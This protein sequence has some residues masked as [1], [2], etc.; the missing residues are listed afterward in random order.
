MSLNLASSPN[1]NSRFRR[2]ELNDGVVFR[3]QLTIPNA[4]LNTTV[5][6]VQIRGSLVYDVPTNCV[7]Y[8]NGQQ[9]FPL[10]TS[11]LV[12]CCCTCTTQMLNVMTQIVNNALTFP[13]PVTITLEEGVVL[14]GHLI[15][16]F[17]NG[18]FILDTLAFGNV[19]KVKSL[20]LSQGDSFTNGSGDLL[21]TLLPAPQSAPVTCSENCEFAMR[22]TALDLI[23]IPV[24]ILMGDGQTFSTTIR[25]VG[26][27]ILFAGAS[28][29]AVDLAI[30]L[31]EI[32]AII[33]NIGDTAAKAAK[34]NALKLRL[35]TKD[36]TKA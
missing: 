11:A 17:D 22:E 34:L 23:G 6:L 30:S 13:N 26:F 21:V 19:C 32:K 4:F 18:V 16:I 20:Q 7:Y 12:E 9:W 5:P 28:P 27:G 8:S 1:A 31:C 25:Q 14:T 33:L 35:S 24:S 2:D 29:T 15:S 3:N 36:K 10:C